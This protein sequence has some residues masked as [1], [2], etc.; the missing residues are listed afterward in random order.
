MNRTNSVIFY[1]LL[2]IIA[3]TAMLNTWLYLR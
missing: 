2:T 3:V 1:A